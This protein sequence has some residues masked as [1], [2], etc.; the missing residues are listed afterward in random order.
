MTN[1]SLVFMQPTGSHGWTWSS[2]MQTAVRHSAVAGDRLQGNGCGA[3]LGQS[4]S[5]KFPCSCVLS[6]FPD[7]MQCAA[8]IG[9]MLGCVETPGM[10]VLK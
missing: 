5:A 8:V 2:S 7:A 1:S 3:K 10:V 9:G 6:A 4:C